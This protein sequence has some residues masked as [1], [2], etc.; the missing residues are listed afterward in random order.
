MASAPVPQSE[1][2]GSA[3][4]LRVRDRVAAIH[5]GGGGVRAHTESARRGS[6]SEQVKRINEGSAQKPK[7][8]KGSSVSK[9]IKNIEE[10]TGSTRKSIT[11]ASTSI[12]ERMAAFERQ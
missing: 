3:T 7:L 2:S 10:N 8:E 5:E 1:D 4:P 11:G 6:V 12:K 9:L